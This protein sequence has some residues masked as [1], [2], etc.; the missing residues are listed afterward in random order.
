M[1]APFVSDKVLR[2]SRYHGLGLYYHGFA[3]FL[4]KDHMAAGRSLTMLAPFE[5]PVFGTHARYL[6]ARVHHASGR[7]PAAW[8]TRASR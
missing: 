3:C 2:K 6:L 8:W 5:G 7:S 4:L 1:A